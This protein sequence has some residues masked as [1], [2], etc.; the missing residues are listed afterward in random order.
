M[1]QFGPTATPISLAGATSSVST[2]VPSG[3]L[4]ICA[5]LASN[6]PVDELALGGE[7]DR[8]GKRFCQDRGGH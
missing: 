8:L 2:S 5:E 7:H 6:A 3:T 4:K 1:L